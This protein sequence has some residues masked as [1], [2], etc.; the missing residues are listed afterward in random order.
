MTQESNTR[1]ITR[2]PTPPGQ[3]LAEG[4]LK[5]HGITVTALAEATGLSRKHLSGII[6]GHA[7]I[8]ADTAVRL[9]AVLGTAPETWLTLQ[10]KLDVW[11]SRQALAHGTAKPVEVGRFAPP[12][13][14]MTAGE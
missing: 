2:R 10:N 7:G 6:H 5:P 4:F 8:T 12:A 13:D 3:I 1:T 11:D 9:A 14:A